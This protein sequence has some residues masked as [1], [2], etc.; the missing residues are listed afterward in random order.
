MTA[1]ELREMTPTELI[2]WFTRSVEVERISRGQ[3]TQI[4]QPVK[5]ED[6]EDDEGAPEPVVFQETI[7]SSRQDF[8]EFKK[9]LRPDQKLLAAP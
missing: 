7:I 3:P 1:E 8:L 5:K 4:L 2:G 6:E 9:N